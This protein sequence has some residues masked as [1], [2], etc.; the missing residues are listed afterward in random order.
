MTGMYHHPHLFS[1]EISTQIFFPVL[2]RSHNPPNL[3]LPSRWNN[4][5]AKLWFAMVVSLI[6]AWDGLEVQLS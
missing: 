5:H 2:A 6:F 4:R 1:I 3:S